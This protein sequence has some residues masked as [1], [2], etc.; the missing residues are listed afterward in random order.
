M[1]LRAFFIDSGWGFALT[2]IALGSI[3][4]N[5]Y[6]FLSTRKSK[7]LICTFNVEPFGKA[8]KELIDRTELITKLPE[9]TRFEICLKNIGNVDLSSDYFESPIKYEFGIDVEYLQL[10]VSD[11]NILNDSLNKE[12]NKIIISPFL[13]KSGEELLITGFVSSRRPIKLV[14]PSV[15]INEFKIIEFDKE[16]NQNSEPIYKNIVESIFVVTVVSVLFFGLDQIIRN[17]LWITFLILAVMFSF[18][19]MFVYINKRQKL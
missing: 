18:L 1:T 19:L 15:R 3:A 13:L 8:V 10:D 17:N 2:L 12:K 14:K 6:Q 9:L 5:I 16:T 4:F 11:I 7:Q